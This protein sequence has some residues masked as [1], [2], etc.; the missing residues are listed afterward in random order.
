[1]KTRTYQKA[2]EYCNATGF[3]STTQRIGSASSSTT[4]TCPVCKGNKTVLVT[5]TETI[6]VNLTKQPKILIS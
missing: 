1:M 4:E 2:C 5:E 6:E 3:V